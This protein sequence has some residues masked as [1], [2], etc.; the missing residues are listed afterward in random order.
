MKL[1]FFRPIFPVSLFVF[2]FIIQPIDAA[3]LQTFPEIQGETLLGESIQFPKA[4]SGDTARLIIGFSRGSQAATTSCANTI[5]SHFK[6]QVYSLSVIQGVPFFIKGLVKNKI[7]DSVL[8]PKRGWNI[9][10]EDGRATL[11]QIASFDQKHED[12]AY[13]VCVHRSAGENFEIVLKTHSLCKD[14]D[15]KSLLEEMKKVC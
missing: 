7:R 14:Q 4:F 3:P 9:L 10:I 12:D 15:L 13:I 5:E 2:F 1:P 11:E 8:L 6:S